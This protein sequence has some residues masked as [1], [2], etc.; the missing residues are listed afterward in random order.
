VLTKLGQVELPKKHL[1]CPNKN[2]FKITAKLQEEICLMGQAVVYREASELMEKLFDL[3]LSDQQIRRVC[4]HYGEVLD[5][6]IKANIEHMIPQ[7]EDT[8]TEDPTYIMMDGSMLFTR[9]GEWK[10]LK[11]ARIFKGSKVIDIQ[12]NRKEIVDTVYCSHLG[13]VK[14]F[15]PKL[16]RHLVNYKHLVIVA[17]GAPW[18]WNWC[19]D[20]YPG[21]VQILDF[22]HAKEKLVLLAN[23]HFKVPEKKKEWLSEQL[24]LLKNDGVL[25]V[26]KN[27]RNLACRNKSA[28]EAKEKLLKYYND[29]ED[30]MAYKTLKE[31]GY[32]IGSGP[33]E[34]AHR[35]VIQQR[36]K[37]SGQKWSI[38][39]A[40]AMANLRCFRKSDSWD[41]IVNL[42]RICA[43]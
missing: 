20:N 33:I 16:E 19:E 26:M 21:C 7:V 28:K 43:A 10:E 15:F 17:D 27:V 22:Y 12:K 23:A 31:N 42:I 40:N 8:K 41:K 39:G 36:M 1:L 13:S 38:D 4:V 9:T 3:H 18:I 32:L 2:S 6:A 5:K 34:A 24:R 29:H 30:R 11:L 37:L 25:Q 14:E 35:S